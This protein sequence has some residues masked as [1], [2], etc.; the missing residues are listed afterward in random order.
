MEIHSND[1]NDILFYMVN[2]YN[3]TVIKTDRIQL[4]IENRAVPI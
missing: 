4:L 1:T 3:F 2:D